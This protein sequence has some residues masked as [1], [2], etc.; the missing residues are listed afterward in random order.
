MYSFKKI[1]IAVDLSEMDKYLLT[2]I[3]GLC[4]L[5]KPTKVY[6]LNIQK[7]LDLDAEEKTLLG[8]ANNLPVDEYVQSKINSNLESYFTYK[9][10]VEVE[11]EV[12]EGKPAEEVLRWADIKK[13]DLLVMGRKAS[14][15]GQGIMPQE[16]ASKVKCSI[17]LVPENVAKFSLTNVFVPI[18]FNEE[19]KLALEEALYIQ[20][21]TSQVLDINCHYVFEL[22]LGHEKSGKTDQE[23]ADILNINAAKKFKKLKL[24]LGSEASQLDYSTELLKDGNI[25]KALNV[26]A[27]ELKSDL[28]I[29]GAKCK[30]L[31]A[32]LFLGNTTKKMIINDSSI[33][34]LIIKE[35]NETF[36]FWDFFNKL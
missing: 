29:M 22:P 36:G 5:I 32:Q 15:T 23:F 6:I 8:Y 31:A 25:A 1:M 28:I 34:L 16:I 30:T 17:L 14:L 13:T 2:Y 19:T 9:N 12:V 4:Q 26:K 35:K 11:I 10:Q 33:P 7:N 27:I 20:K 3:N 21:E 18:N 24:D